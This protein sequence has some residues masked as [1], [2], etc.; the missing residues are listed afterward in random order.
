MKCP[1]RV[2]FGITAGVFLA[3]CLR[4]LSAAPKPA[5]A[6]PTPTVA[7]PAELTALRTAYETKLAPLNEKLREAIKKRAERYA[8]DLNNLMQQAAGSGKTDAI[9]PLKKEQEAYTTGKF[10]SGLDPQNRKVPPAARE[11]R[12]N[13]DQDVA[14]I[15]ADLAASAKPMAAEYVKQLTE[16]EGTM[17]KNKDATG[18]LAVREEKK[19]VAQA[20]TFDPLFGGNP[21]VSGRWLNAADGWVNLR[22]DS[23]VSDAGGASGTW[24]WEDRG[25]RKVYIHWQGYRGTWSYTMTPDGGGMIGANEKK[26]RVIL[27]RDSAR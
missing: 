17:M 20:A 19:A 22:P 10:S 12:R 3:L 23:K 16:L 2:P 1:L 18:L 7:D 11:L 9:E 6:P 26:E 27:N 13:Y 14:K 5:P 8:T 15:R 21:V 4:P 24:E 25:R